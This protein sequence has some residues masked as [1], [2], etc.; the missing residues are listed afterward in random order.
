MQTEQTSLPTIKLYH[1]EAR[2]TLRE[3]K[4]HSINL[5]YLNPPAGYTEILRKMLFDIRRVMHAER[6]TV[7]LHQSLEIQ[8]FLVEG[9]NQ[10]FSNGAWDQRVIKWGDERICQCRRMGAEYNSS[11]VYLNKSET[12]LTRDEI[13]SI[14]IDSSTEKGDLVLDPF[15]GESDSMLVAAKMGRL[16]IGADTRLEAVARLQERLPA[17]AGGIIDEALGNSF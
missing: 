15:C 14:M 4:S 6:A 11:F 9:W 2:Q 7:Y 16:G 12:L 13:L 5:L 3:V 17:G 8:T 1:K 10:T